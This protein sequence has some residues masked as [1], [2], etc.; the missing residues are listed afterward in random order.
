MID[1]FAAG[2]CLVRGARALRGAGASAA[3]GPRGVRAGLGWADVGRGMAGPG[4]GRAEG[5]GPVGIGVGCWSGTKAGAS[6]FIRRAAAAGGTRAAMAGSA[7]GAA[8]ARCGEVG[9]WPCDGMRGLSA[10]GR[11]SWGLGACAGPPLGTKGGACGLNLGT[12][13]AAG[14]G[15]TEAPVPGAAPDSMGA[16]VTCSC[17]WR[18]APCADAASG[19]IW[20]PTGP[21]PSRPA[22]VDR[23]GRAWCCCSHAGMRWRGR[24]EE[25]WGG[26]PPL[27]RPAGWL[28]RGGRD[29]EPSGASS[30][31]LRGVGLGGSCDAGTCACACAAIGFTI[32]V[33]CLIGR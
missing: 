1:W 2:R 22:A 18:V 15:G 4:S 11:A 12:A 24:W 3:A 14:G 9:S 27:G 19:R 20:M 23:G 28:G 5:C 32:D 17:G 8:A 33:P 26:H 21:A 25:G 13:A 31:L 30:D 16:A 7:P 29:D 10:M 6:G